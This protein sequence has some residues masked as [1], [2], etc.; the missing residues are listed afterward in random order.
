MLELKNFLLVVLDLL[1]SFLLK[2]LIKAFLT[3]D[4]K[5]LSEF[6]LLVLALSDFLFGTLR[7]SK[8]E[9]K[10]NDVFTNLTIESTILFL[11]LSFSEDDLHYS[12]HVFFIE[13]SC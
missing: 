8:V 5:F 13:M 7:S 9:F 10:F 2:E 3:I 12:L 6:T 1:I 4:K 11:I